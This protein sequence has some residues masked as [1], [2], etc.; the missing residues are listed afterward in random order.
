MPTIEPPPPNVGDEQAGRTEGKPTGVAHILWLLKKAGE[1]VSEIED[2]GKALSW[3]KDRLGL[4]G[5]EDDC[6]RCDAARARGDQFCPD[7]GK[8]LR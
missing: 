1:K 4:G 7:C 6:P 8:R 2:V 5:D 3:I